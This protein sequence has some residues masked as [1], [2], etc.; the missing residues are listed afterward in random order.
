MTPVSCSPPDRRPGLLVPVA[1]WPGSGARRCAQTRSYRQRHGRPGDSR[2]ADGDVR[3]PTA[4]SR[5]A[6][7]SCR[8]NT[9][10][11]NHSLQLRGPAWDP[12]S[13]KARRLQRINTFFLK[14]TRDGRRAAQRRTGDTNPN[15]NEVASG[16][17]T[18]TPRLADDHLARRRQHVHG[19]MRCT[20]AARDLHRRR[21]R[22]H[23]RVGC[24]IEARSSPPS[25]RGE[26]DV[27]GGT[28][29]ARATGSREERGRPDG[30]LRGASATGNR[31]LGNVPHG[32]LGGVQVSGS[33]RHSSAGAA[34]G[35]T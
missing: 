34:A 16:A 2:A 28:A 29:P 10:A 18:R 33:R 31:I 6:R 4:A 15:G 22:G 26:P 17:S 1:A 3:G 35:A 12:S 23:P 21:R 25:V 19:P 8:D 30:D 20:G 13:R 32:L 27:I 14:A 5:F 7:P 24:T 11:R 9:P